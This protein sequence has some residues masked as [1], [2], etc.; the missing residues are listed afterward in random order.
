MKHNTNINAMA[1]PNNSREN[2]LLVHS[3]F[4][5]PTINSL[6]NW[7]S[8]FFFSFN[9]VVILTIVVSE[10]SLPEHRLQW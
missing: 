8:V 9:F 2:D 7:F 6:D 10:I 1:R 4:H 5:S 3:V